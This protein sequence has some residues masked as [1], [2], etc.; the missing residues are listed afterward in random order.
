MNR[1]AAFAVGAALVLTLG[2]KNG[3]DGSARK[4]LGLNP[5]PM[6]RTS[7]PISKELAKLPDANKEVAARVDNMSQTL[8]ARNTFAGFDPGLKVA[9]IGVKESVLFH[10]GDFLVVIS[11]G[12]V[13]KCDSD[14]QLAALLCTE[15]GQMA[16]EQ[17]AAKARRGDKEPMPPLN[18]GGDAL[19]PGGSPT[20]AG[21]QAELA[22]HE[23]KYPK[24]TARPE[25]VD[26][27]AV[28]RDL[29]KGANFS[30]AELDCVEPLLKLSPRSDQLRKQFGGS[31]PPPEWK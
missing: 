6:D 1:L 30:P 15:L 14:G 12:L 8:I 16:A 20:D 25:P 31:S 19:Q 4:A 26:P 13:E 7:R 2:C 5:P 10:V 3:D 24:S 27:V 18:P 23:K 28:A 9:V 17:R 21:R 22:Y 29:L 11:E